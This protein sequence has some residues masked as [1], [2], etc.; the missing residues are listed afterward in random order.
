MKG[1]GE[2]ER[3]KGHR[4]QRENGEVG[5]KMERTGEKREKRNGGG[6]EEGWETGSG[7]GE[8]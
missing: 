2:G 8:G 7:K 1:D 5:S 3:E 6:G 4:G